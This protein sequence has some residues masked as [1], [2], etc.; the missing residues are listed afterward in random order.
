MQRKGSATAMSGSNLCKWTISYFWAAIMWLLSAEVLMVGGFGF[1][2]AGL[3]SADTLVIVHMVCIGWLSLAM[4]GAL[5]QF[6]PVLV[7]RPL[8]AE[9]WT[10]P[11]LV[12]LSAGLMAL[13]AGF[14]A[15]GGRI[16]PWLSLLPVGA[17]LLIAGFALVVG[18]VGM[19]LFQAHPLAGPARFVSVGLVSICAT[20]TFG[21][22]F[23]LVLSGRATGPLLTNMLDAVPVHAIAGLG[24]WLTF[25]A[26]GVTYRLLAMFMLAP[27]ADVSLGRRAW[28]VGAATLAI[29]VIGGVFALLVAGGLN[30]VLWLAAMSGAASLAFYG[31]DVRGLY[32]ARKRRALE[33]N[34]HMVVWSFASLAAVAFLGG[35]LA[36]TGSFARHVGAFVFL[37]VFGWLSGLVLANLYKIVPFLT[38]LEAYG[39]V[40]GKVPTPRVQDLVAERRASKWFVLFFLASWAATAMLLVEAPAGFRVAVAAMMIATLGIAQQL[41]RARQL[42]EVA[43]ALRLPTGVSAPW[44]LLSRN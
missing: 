38:W 37:A 41:V 32:R 36:A 24:G 30:L 44:L 39:P 17:I 1:P 2:N 40:L 25:T 23:S 31:H 7:A 4:C 22:M 27:D 12:L 9:R 11:A 3:M 18:D 13:L 8:Y 42:A 26:M 20:V 15:L 28:L 16:S 43:E 19:T 35:A 6:V 14:L 21:V 5:F 33:L 34:T 29:A 10:L